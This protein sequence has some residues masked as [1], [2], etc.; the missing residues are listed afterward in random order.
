MVEGARTCV[1]T[2]VCLPTR[3]NSP[4]DTSDNERYSRSKEDISPVTKMVFSLFKVLAFMWFAGPLD[5]AFVLVKC[6]LASGLLPRS[7]F[8]GWRPKKQLQSPC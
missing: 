2:C 3:V 6:K 7:G 5:A 1:Y 8:L 4:I